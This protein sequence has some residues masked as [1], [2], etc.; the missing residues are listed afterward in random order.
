[1]LFFA[2][3]EKAAVLLHK[4]GDE[5]GEE[6]ERVWL[7]LRVCIGRGHH[8]DDL[9][10]NLRLRQNLEEGL[11]LAEIV[12]CRTRVQGHVQVILVSCRQLFDE[13]GHYHSGL[14][15]QHLLHRPL[16]GGEFRLGWLVHFGVAVVGGLPLVFLL[17]L[18]LLLNEF[19]H[20]RGQRVLV[21]VA[22]QAVE[23]LAF[24]VQEQVLKRALL[25]LVQHLLHDLEEV[26]AQDG[27][28]VLVFVQELAH[29][30]QK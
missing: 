26:A 20:Q 1:M 14:L 8:E 11:V 30:V 23:D 19:D 6:I 3:L 7:V 4:L 18:D 2:V 9:A 27:Q 29:R 15:L 22:E 16:C 10:D 17:W 21:Q 13:G 25:L 28:R 5:S 12:E 24:L